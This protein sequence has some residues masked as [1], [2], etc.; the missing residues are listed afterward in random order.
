MGLKSESKP[1]V[2]GLPGLK[3]LRE[4]YS[5]TTGKKLEQ[6]DLAAKL[7]ISAASVSAWETGR[8]NAN[9]VSRR[10]LAQFFGVDEAQLLSEGP[11]TATKPADTVRFVL[12]RLGYAPDDLIKLNEHDWRT[13]QSVLDPLIQRLL[14]EKSVGKKG[15]GN[16]E[17]KSVF[18][19]DDDIQVCHETTQALE[20]RGFKVDYAFNGEA[21][22][23]RLIERMERPDLIILDLHM[24][25]MDG[26]GFLKKL[27]GINNHS[28]ILILTAYPRD[29][30]ELESAELK[31][32]GF[33]EKPAPTEKLLTKI[34]ELLE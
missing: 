14:E 18:I 1:L 7:G 32:D 26:K 33:L 13:I 15:A 24:P 17:V 25:E 2:K 9:A 28:K 12:E 22:M 8:R 19:V 10:K 29:V 27:C 11:S 4:A 21:A 31:Y 30:A 20:Q 23:K 6:E 3:Q 34:E 5:R 16:P